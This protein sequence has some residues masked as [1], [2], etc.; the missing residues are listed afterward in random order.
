MPKHYLF[1]R[2][3]SKDVQKKKKIVFPLNGNVVKLQHACSD[4]ILSA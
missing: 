4:C 3:V 2:K 1:H